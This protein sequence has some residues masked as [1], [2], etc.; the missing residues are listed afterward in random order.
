MNRERRGGR[1]RIRS[2]SL[3]ERL[4]AE[5]AKGRTL[6]VLVPRNALNAFQAS[7]AWIR[8][9][10]WGRFMAALRF[11]QSRLALDFRALILDLGPGPGGPGL[12]RWRAGECPRF[13]QLVEGAVGGHKGDA[14]GPQVG[15]EAHR[16]APL[17]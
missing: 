11:R 16:C 2:P 17:P 13:K 1:V 14:P 15:K 6:A 12:P 4:E 5:K 8:R 7:W 9:S 10:Q 3:T